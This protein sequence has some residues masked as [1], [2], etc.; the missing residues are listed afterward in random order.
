[1]PYFD[2]KF[3]GST[4]TLTMLWRNSRQKMLKACKQDGGYQ[5]SHGSVALTEWLRRFY[6]IWN[7]RNRDI[8]LEILCGT[9]CSQEMFLKAFESLEIMFLIVGATPESSIC[10]QRSEKRYSAATPLFLWCYRRK[11][12]L[13]NMGKGTKQNLTE[14][15]RERSVLCIITGHHNIMT[16]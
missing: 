7:T 15:K 9:L 6:S 13:K 16:K 4:A 10:K 8:C 2:R 3:R 1:M 14:N 11:W 12:G 5:F